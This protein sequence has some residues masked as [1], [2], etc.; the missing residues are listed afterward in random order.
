[1]NSI[2]TERK[3]TLGNNAFYIHSF[4]R[5][6]FTQFLMIIIWMD[7]VLPNRWNI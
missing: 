1:M 5:K 6:I 7:Q 2:D 4:F 3:I